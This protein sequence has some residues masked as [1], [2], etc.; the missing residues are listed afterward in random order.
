MAVKTNSSFQLRVKHFAVITFAVLVF[1]LAACSQSSEWQ[2]QYD[3]GVRY[4]SDGNYEEAIIAFT[5]AIEIEPKLAEAYIGLAN[6]YLAM[7][8]EDLAYNAIID[9][10][11]A[12]EDEPQIFDDYIN[13]NFDGKSY[14]IN[15]EMTKLLRNGILAIDNVPNVVDYIGGYRGI[16]IGDTMESVLEKLGFGSGHNFS[17]AYINVEDDPRDSTFEYCNVPVRILS[18]PLSGDNAVPDI[19]VVFYDE[20]GEEIYV[21][22]YIFEDQVHL[23]E[24]VYW[25]MLN[26]ID[27]VEVSD[28]EHIIINKYY[29][30]SG[31]LVKRE[32]YR[33]GELVDFSEYD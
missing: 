7:G 8:E 10:I 31:D 20:E 2:E 9:G 13:K 28:G 32:E 22:I 16:V 18:G 25:D 15:A 4:L 14:K 33:D 23:T 6:T 30:A 11:N 29:E 19:E 5:A 1:V 27:V 21:F 17:A 3:L 12:C 26:D 24:I